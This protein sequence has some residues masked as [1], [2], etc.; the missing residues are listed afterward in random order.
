MYEILKRIIREDEYELR[1][2]L[3][4]I[5]MMYA[6]GR[7][8]LDEMEE[9]KM[10]ARKNAKSE[11]SYATVQE[12]IKKAFEMIAMLQA[13]IDEMKEIGSSEG[14]EETD[15]WSEWKQPTGAHD[16]Y[17]A[18]MKMTFTD[19]KR[20]TCIAPEGVACVWGPDVMPGYWMVEE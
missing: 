16:A 2:M 5:E 1:E 4:R 12:Q 10:M 6:G 13:Q 8:S 19:G 15:E 3:L 20:Y 14:G 9:L 11:N 17:Y 7:I 18:G